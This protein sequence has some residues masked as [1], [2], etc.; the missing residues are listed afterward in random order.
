MPSMPGSYDPNEGLRLFDA[1]RR[2]DAERVFREVILDGDS[3]GAGHYGMALIH[4]VRQEQEQARRHLLTSIRIEPNHAHANFY[5]GNI[6]RDG[7]NTAEAV[8]LY[9]RALEINPGHVGARRALDSLPS[10]TDSYASAYAPASPAP[11]PISTPI[12]QPPVGFAPPVNETISGNDLYALLRRSREPVEIEISQH[13]DTIASIIG[14]RKRR[15]SAYLGS[16]I[17]MTLLWLV[18]AVVI[19]V[20]LRAPVAALAIFLIWLVSIIIKCV[21]IRSVNLSIDRDWLVI[22]TGVLSTHKNQLNTF[23]ASRA[24]VSIHRS[25]LNRMTNNGTIIL[26]GEAEPGKYP[27]SSLTLLGFFTREELDT[28]SSAFRRLSLLQPVTRDIQNA[29]GLL[30]NIRSGNN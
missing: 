10:T 18:A 23:M 16:F 11:P 9:R 17:S 26:L 7:G 21:T 1:G 27:P 3:T 25:L 30:K 5:L 12:S 29:I 28:L 22:K 19:V 6:S 2:D 8:R 15:L 4:L 13:L 24:Q 20:A 14:F